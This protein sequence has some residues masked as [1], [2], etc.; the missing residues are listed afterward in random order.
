M[1]APAFALAQRWYFA[2]VQAGL[3]E[4]PAR[5]Q[6]REGGAR[7]G[8]HL[9]ATL[10]GR[11]ARS[12][13]VAL[14]VREWRLLLRTPPF[15]LPVVTNVLV[16]P[17]VVAMMLLFIPSDESG[18]SVIALLQGV[19]PR[20]LAAAL[21]GLIIFMGSNQVAPTSISREGKGLAQVAALPATPSEQV[22][23]RLLVAAPFGL[24]TAFV[25]AGVA[26]WVVKMPLETAAVGLAIGIAGLWPSTAGGLWVDLLRPVTNWDSPQQAMK[27]NINGLWGM[28]VALA[29]AA[30][31][32]GAG[33]LVWRASGELSWAL[34]T[35]TVGLLALGAVLTWLC[36]RQAT[37]LFENAGETT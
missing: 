15:M 32:G 16:P 10:L 5:R 14:A 11:P 18:G 34:G 4:P 35:A 6:R 25:M 13:M 21:A 17:L 7:E 28:V 2:G 29:T 20:W 19:D 3:E 24:A 22:G 36:M 8:G 33:Y 30:V 9:A 1:T 23:A 31:S 37:R 26:W 27:G 12:R